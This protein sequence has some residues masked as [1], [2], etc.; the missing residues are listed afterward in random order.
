M[1]GGALSLRELARGTD[2]PNRAGRLLSDTGD[3]LAAILREGTQ[4]NRQVAGSWQ[5]A[6]QWVATEWFP[7]LFATGLGRFAWIAPPH[8]PGLF[9]IARTLQLSRQQ[10]N[11]INTFLDPGPAKAWLLEDG[12]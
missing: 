10:E 3:P 5:E 2:T 12:E 11:E 9:S 6:S 8:T 7:Q 1:P 4:D